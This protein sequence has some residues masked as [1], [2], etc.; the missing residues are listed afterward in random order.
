VG[1]SVELFLKGH[2]L[3]YH[4]TPRPLSPSPCHGNDCLQAQ[5]A[6]RVKGQAFDIQRRRQGKLCLPRSPPALLCSP[7]TARCCR[8]LPGINAWARYSGKQRSECKAGRAPRSPFVFEYS[9]KMNCQNEF[10]G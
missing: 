5:T 4:R 8:T 3:P 2:P 1:G 9:C 10:L 6:N 7:G